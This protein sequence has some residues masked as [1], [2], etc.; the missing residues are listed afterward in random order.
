MMIPKAHMPPNA[1]ENWKK[2]TAARPLEPK[3]WSKIS[4]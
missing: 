1:N 4:M 2:E 3:Q